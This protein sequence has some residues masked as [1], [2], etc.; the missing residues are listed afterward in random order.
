MI[1]D[2]LNSSVCLIISVI[3][4]FILV[5]RWAKRLRCLRRAMPTRSVHSARI[6]QRF[7]G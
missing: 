4:V 6:F 7:I 3:T 5:Y 1:F 2:F